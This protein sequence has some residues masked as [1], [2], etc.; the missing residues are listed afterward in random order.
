MEDGVVHLREKRLFE[1]YIISC[2]AAD[3]AHSI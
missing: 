3:A 1:A 2:E